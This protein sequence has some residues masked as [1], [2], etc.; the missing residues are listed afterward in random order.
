VQRKFRAHYLWIFDIL[1]IL[2]GKSSFARE[3][4]EAAR[5][6]QGI[7]SLKRLIVVTPSLAINNVDQ[8]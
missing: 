1:A 7:D 4:S 3:S 2:G 8:S 5:L 6:V